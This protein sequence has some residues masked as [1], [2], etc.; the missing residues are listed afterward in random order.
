[1]NNV[2]PLAPKRSTRA[3]HPISFT[4]RSRSLTQKRASARF[5]ELRLNRP[6]L[7][8]CIRRAASHNLL[9]RRSVPGIFDKEHTHSL[10]VAV[11]VLDFH[12]VVIANSHDR[13]AAFN[14]Q[15][16]NAKAKRLFF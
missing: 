12:P 16:L 13:I 5:H 9:H 7:E 3:F 2:A 10:L 6:G 11:W 14:P 15:G 4:K 8:G 1:M